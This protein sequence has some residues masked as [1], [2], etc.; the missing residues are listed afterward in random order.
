MDTYEIAVLKWISEQ[1]EPLTTTEIHRH[2]SA[3]MSFLTT[4]SV[5]S[6]LV[7]QRLLEQGIPRGL[8][9][10]WQFRKSQDS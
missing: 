5:L 9:E 7:A 3:T 2:F 1:E 8:M 6:S 4:R 10:T